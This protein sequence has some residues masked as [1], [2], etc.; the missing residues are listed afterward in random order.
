MLYGIEKNRIKRKM[1]V[2]RVA[3]SLRIGTE[4]YYSWIAEKEEVPASALESL[5]KL[6][7]CS[8]DSLL[9]DKTESMKEDASQGFSLTDKMLGE[10]IDSEIDR[11][12]EK[13]EIIDMIAKI[14]DEAGEDLGS[15]LFQKIIYISCECYIKGLR[16]GA[17]RA[18]LTLQEAMS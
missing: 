6:F 7:C 1:S 16:G 3:A 14:I 18:M 5:A 11:L 10:M 12:L 17:R 2:E 4:T 9:F 8:V 15:S 13:G